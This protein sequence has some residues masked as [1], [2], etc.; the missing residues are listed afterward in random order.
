MVNIHN[1]RE[2]MTFEVDQLRP[3]RWKVIIL[4]MRIMTTIITKMEMVMMIIILSG[5]IQACHVR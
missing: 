4:E 2:D 5:L 1:W 3:V